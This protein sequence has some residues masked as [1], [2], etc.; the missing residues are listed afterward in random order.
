MRTCECGCVCPNPERLEVHKRNCPVLLQATIAKMKSDNKDLALMFDSYF[1][2]AKGR[3]FAHDEQ[4]Q[5]FI[6][7]LAK[8]EKNT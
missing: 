3:Y 8:L 2:Y 6:E 5:E 7:A 1:I 4:A